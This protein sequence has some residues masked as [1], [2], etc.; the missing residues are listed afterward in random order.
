M[1][2]QAVVMAAGRASQ[3]T[4]LTHSMPKCLLPI[5]NKPLIWFSLKMLENHGFEGLNDLT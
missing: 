3:M 4:D 1:E 5:G 2:Y